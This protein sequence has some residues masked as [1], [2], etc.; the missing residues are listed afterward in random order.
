VVVLVFLRQSC[1]VAHW[2]YSSNLHLPSEGIIQMSVITPASHVMFEHLKYSESK[3]N[4]AIN[5]I[6]FKKIHVF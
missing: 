5:A 1:S 4:C 2:P 3:L 6:L